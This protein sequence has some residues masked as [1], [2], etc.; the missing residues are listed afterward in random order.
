MRCTKPSHEVILSVLVPAA[1]A[2]LSGPPVLGSACLSLGPPSSAAV[3]PAVSERTALRLFPSQCEAACPAL[4]VELPGC[5]LPVSPPE[6]KDQKETRMRQMI[7]LNITGTGNINTLALF[8]TDALLNVYLETAA[9][10]IVHDL[11]ID[12]FL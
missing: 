10:V 3:G 6:G 8:S 12:N 9:Q 7:I 2:E 11:H 4:P 1:A 5:C